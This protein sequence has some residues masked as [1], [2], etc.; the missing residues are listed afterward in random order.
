MT[1]ILIKTGNLGAETDMHGNK[2]R[3]KQGEHDVKMENWS[4][5][6]TS[7][8]RPRCLADHQGLRKGKE[9]FPTGFRENMAPC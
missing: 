9:G 7:L 4:D 1:D 5:A 3:W 2:V 6:L 8:R